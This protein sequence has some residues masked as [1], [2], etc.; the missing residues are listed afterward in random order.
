MPI[1]AVLGSF[2]N[3]QIR[4]RNASQ[5]ED[6][7]NILITS[8]NSA[9]IAVANLN[10]TSLTILN[11]GPGDLRWRTMDEGAPTATDGFLLKKGASIEVN[12]LEEVQGFAIG[13]DCNISVQEGEG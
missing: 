12:S 3:S 6:T 10:R 1:V 9:V 8:G 13:A 5:N 7:D 4:P 2:P 11:E